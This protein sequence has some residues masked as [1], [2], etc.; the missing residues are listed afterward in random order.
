VLQATSYKQDT[1][2]IVLKMRTVNLEEY[3]FYTRYAD[4][5]ANDT[6]ITQPFF[7]FYTEQPA[8]VFQKIQTLLHRI[9]S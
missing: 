2:V 7:I 3:N 5:Y 1:D 4:P 9:G 6:F 8:E